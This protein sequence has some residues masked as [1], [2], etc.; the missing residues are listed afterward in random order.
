[1]QMTLY[2]RGLDYVKLISQVFWIEHYFTIHLK[3][4][5]SDSDT[6]HLIFDAFLLMER[7]DKAEQN[8]NTF[9]NGNFYEFCE[10]RGSMSEDQR[11]KDSKMKPPPKKNP[12][13][14]QKNKK[15]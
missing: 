11:A 5:I 3:P 4:N 12:N 2:L 7:Y 8:L 13:K 10:L 1:M 15:S 14:K 9:Y 6:L